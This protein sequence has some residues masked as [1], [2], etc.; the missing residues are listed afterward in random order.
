[1]IPKGLFMNV[2]MILVSGGIIFTY[3]MPTFEVIGSTQN[4]R[5]VYQDELNRVVDV[6][7]RLNELKRSADGISVEERSALTTYL[8]SQ[9][10]PVVVQRD[11][12]FIAEAADISLTSLTVADADSQNP[13]TQ[14]DESAA[15]SSRSELVPHHFTLAF[16]A[17]YSQAKDFLT[18]L[19]TNEYPLRV[20]ELEITPA[21]SEGS[22]TVAPG[23]SDEVTVSITVTTYSFVVNTLAP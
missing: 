20:T 9:I 1:M 7:T 23:G 19:G 18:I 22:A 21:G 3:I 11:L 5:K 17:P 4:E 16:T 15:T 14:T 2:G 13:V 10:D 12:L 6:T 8:P